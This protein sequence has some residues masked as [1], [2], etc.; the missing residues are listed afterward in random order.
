MTDSGT[1]SRRSSGSEKIKELEEINSIV[2]GKNILITGGVGGLGQA[3]VNHFL[4][5]GVNVSKI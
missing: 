5:H 4:Q 3:F 2:A 1:R